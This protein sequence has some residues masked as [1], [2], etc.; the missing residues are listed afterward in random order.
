MKK[1]QVLYWNG[2][3]L[4]VNVIS[5]TEGGAAFEGV[6]G[7]PLSSRALALIHLAMYDAALGTSSTATFKNKT[8]YAS[9]GVPTIAG[10][11]Q[12]VAIATAAKAMLFKLYP[13]LRSFFDA[14]YNEAGLNFSN[15]N[16]SNGVKYGLAVA[17]AVWELRKDDPNNKDIGYVTSL[18]RGMHR[19]DPNNLKPNEAPF[20]GEKSKTFVV[21][22]R[23]GI[24]KPYGLKTPQYQS[25]LKQVIGKGI[26]PSQMGFLPNSYSK[27]TAEET[28]IGIYW[29]Y[30]GSK[31][32]GTPPRFFNQII[33]KVIENESFL[34]LPI[35]TEEKN[36]E[37]FALANAAMADAGILAWQQKYEHNFWRPILGIREN[38]PSMGYDES[39]K[40][41]KLDKH[42]DPCW[43]PLGAPSTNSVG[44]NNFTPPFP[45][46]PSGHATFGA[47]ALQIVRLF[48][49]KVNEITKFEKDELFKGLNMVSDEF[50]G[51]N[52]DSD[53]TTRPRHHREF[54]GGLHDMILE[55]GLSRVFLGVHWYF[56]AFEVN[57]DAFKNGSKEGKDLD[58]SE[59]KIDIDLSDANG[60]N[61]GYGGVS[62]GLAI[63]NDI[64]SKGL[65]ASNLI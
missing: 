43:L 60:K 5:H 33:R 35:N 29:G 54:E 10:A 38:D 11:D 40:A 3:A 39:K 4:E 27:R 21:G 15:A 9:S 12:S 14:K 7:P 18:G 13:T 24:K 31:K 64:F 59:I 8:F 16:H 20:Y 26:K 44:A 36:A 50:N 22:K 57:A 56:D 34:K 51:S 17:N 53:G 23:Y 63:A 2:V 32:I 62:L 49:G 28:L 55:N 41:S 6:N 61:I 42:T 45:A 25:A 52:M 1:D 30:D 65:G 46:Y 19:S 37:L 47:A 48:Y 58:L